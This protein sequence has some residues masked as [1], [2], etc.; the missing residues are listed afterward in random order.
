MLLCLDY[1]QRHAVKATSSAAHRTDAFKRVP[2]SPDTF[3]TP[4]V[5][6]MQRRCDEKSVS[7]RTLVVDVVLI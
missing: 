3:K 4:A 5:Q 1:L 7:T 2:D 6:K